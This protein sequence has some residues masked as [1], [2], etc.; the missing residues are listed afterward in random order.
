MKYLRRFTGILAVILIVAVLAFVLSIPV[1]TLHQPPVNQPP[2][3]ANSS[4][5]IFSFY[6]SLLQ[7]GF[8][9]SFNRFAERPSAREGASY[10]EVRRDAW[11]YLFIAFY[12]CCLLAYSFVQRR[13][14]EPPPLVQQHALVRY[15]K[16]SDGRKRVFFTKRV[17]CGEGV[18]SL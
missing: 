4:V 7:E 2:L 5:Q 6:K 18:C 15:L 11:F 16:R 10:E 1:F 3:E 9:G 13:R 8:P 12:M 14:Q 17:R